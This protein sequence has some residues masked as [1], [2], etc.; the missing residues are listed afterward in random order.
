[1]PP[2][3]TIAEI[4]L[5]LFS[6]HMA[7]VTGFVFL[8]SLGFSTVLVSTERNARELGKAFAWTVV[9]MLAVMGLLI[10]RHA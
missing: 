3:E 10:W 7:A 1:M 2:W 9:G 5:L 6:V 8:V 4:A